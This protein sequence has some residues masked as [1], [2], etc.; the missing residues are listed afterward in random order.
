V[1]TTNPTSPSCNSL[2]TPTTSDRVSPTSIRSTPPRH[3]PPRHSITKTEP[4]WLGFLCF[5][6]I[7]PKPPAPACA[8]KRTTPP[9]SP[10]HTPHPSTP[11]HRPPWPF[12]TARPKPSPSGL[13]SDLEPQTPCPRSCH[14]MHH[15][16]ATSTSCTPPQHFP[17]SPSTA[18]FHGAPETEP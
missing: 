3:E 4:R 10:P 15:P 6:C 11:L 13:V 7:H 18:V 12:P 8:I 9:P 5:G 16:A 14:R 2:D 1:S 17:P